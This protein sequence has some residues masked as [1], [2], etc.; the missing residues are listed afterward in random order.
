MPSQ[1]VNATSFA[2]NPSA[3]LSLYELDT[4]YTSPLGSRILF[5]AGVNGLYQSVIWNGE[6]YTAYPIELTESSI[7]GNGSPPRPKLTVSNIHGFVSALLLEQGNLVGARFVRRKVFARFLDASNFANNVNPFGTPDPT[8]A[9]DDEIY[10]VNRKLQENP[11][12]VELELSSP[13]ELD[14]IQLPNR[15]MLATVCPFVYRDGETCGYK[16]PPITDRFGKSFTASAPAGYGYT[17]SDK[18]IWSN[19]VTYQIGDYVTIISQGDFTYGD[20][21][22]YVCAAANV[23]GDVNNPQFNPTNW[24][25]DACAH[26]LLGC[27]QHFATGPIPYGGFLGTSRASYG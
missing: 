5:H 23:T 3:L 24:V 11:A 7:N 26:N 21:L 12:V 15:P 27:K 22:V 4:R 13:F 18:G 25:G 10:F 17:L 6:T 2:S 20:V 1:V 8:A 16:G 19:A 14:N 9:Y